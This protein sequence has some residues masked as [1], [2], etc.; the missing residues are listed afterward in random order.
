MRKNEVKL[1]SG[2]KNFYSGNIFLNEGKIISSSVERVYL[3][4]AI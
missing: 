3:Q 2:V 1:T 4:S